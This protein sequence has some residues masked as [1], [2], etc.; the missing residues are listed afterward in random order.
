MVGK[1]SLVG[2]VRL[3]RDRGRKGGSIVTRRLLLADLRSRLDYGSFTA[4][5][6]APMESRFLVRRFLRH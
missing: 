6:T 5:E 1:P 3:A 2:K 4:G